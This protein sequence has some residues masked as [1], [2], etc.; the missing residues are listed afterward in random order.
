MVLVLALCACV[1]PSHSPVGTDIHTDL[2]LA[3][4]SSGRISRSVHRSR[5]K[6]QAKTIDCLFHWDFSIGVQRGIKE[7]A[8]Q[9][10]D[11]RCTQ[12]VCVFYN[13][14]YK[15]PFWMRSSYMYY[16]FGKIRTTHSNWMRNKKESHLSVE[17][18]W[19]FLV[20]RRLV[21]KSLLQF[22]VLLPQIIY[23]MLI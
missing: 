12:N 9:G 13:L 1:C 8:T 22:N 16:I 3:R 23:I 2:N 18:S 5:S 11:A 14:N 6:S 19:C 15:E 7:E 10:Y 4:R 21:M 17:F 20:F